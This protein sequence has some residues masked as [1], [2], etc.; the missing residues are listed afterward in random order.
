MKQ[1][2]E[3]LKSAIRVELREALGHF[4]KEMELRSIIDRLVKSVQTVLE[5]PQEEPEPKMICEHCG[6]DTSPGSPSTRC[7]RCWNEGFGG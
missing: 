5:T 7:S 1:K 4:V 6:A 3:A 2:K